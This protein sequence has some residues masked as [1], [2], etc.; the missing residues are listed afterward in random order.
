[1]PS[2][3]PNI[4]KPN[5]G[6]GIE[7]NV[8]SFLASA[9]Q[10]HLL[11]ITSRRGLVINPCILVLWNCI[12]HQIKDRK[13]EGIMVILL[14]LFV[15]FSFLFFFWLLFFFPSSYGFDVKISRLKFGKFWK[16]HCICRQIIYLNYMDQI[17]ESTIVE[18]FYQW[19][20]NNAQ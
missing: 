11:D 16:F 12:L 8:M 1:M 2:L 14:N 18:N 10:R 20:T 15:L 4:W 3:T 13:I 17:C 6:K 9:W 7:D 19:N 5:T